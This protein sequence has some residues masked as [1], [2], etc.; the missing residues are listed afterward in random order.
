MLLDFLQ[1]KW[2]S[3]F[4]VLINSIFCF[5][6]LQIGDWVG[7]VLSFGLASLCAYN[8]RTALERENDKSRK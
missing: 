6:A 7:C 1:S 2:T 5:A 3:L 8:F 4:C